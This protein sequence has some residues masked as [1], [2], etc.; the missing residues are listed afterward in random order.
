MAQYRGQ[1]RRII[2]VFVERVILRNGFG[3]RIDYKLGRGATTRFS[4]QRRPPL[5]ENLLKFFLRLRRNLLHRFN[6]QRTQSSFGDFSDAW[7]FSHRKRRQ[8]SLFAS[9]RNANESPRL[10]LIRGHFSHQPRRSEA[11]GT[12][13]TGSARNAAQGFSGGWGAWP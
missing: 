3:F 12:W 8:K 4:I 9:R 2:R 13:Q 7:N 5:P 6:S 10:A 1:S 11:A